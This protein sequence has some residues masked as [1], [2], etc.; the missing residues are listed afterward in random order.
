MKT[1][2]AI[3]EDLLASGIHLNRIYELVGIREELKD[4]NGPDTIRDNVDA[5]PA[6]FARTVPASTWRSKK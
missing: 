5:S 4:L 6:S 3:A 2:G 1:N